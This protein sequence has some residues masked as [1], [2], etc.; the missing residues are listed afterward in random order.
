MCLCFSADERLKDKRE[1]SALI[2]YDGTVMW[3]PLSIFKSTC[4]I[5]ITNFPYDIQVRYREHIHNIV[6][7]FAMTP[8]PVM[9]NNV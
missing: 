7:Y 1:I 6:F 3:V 5:D 4:I 8:I 9:W 2:D